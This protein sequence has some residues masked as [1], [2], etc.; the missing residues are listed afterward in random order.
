MFDREITLF[1]IV[2]FLP[3]FQS[4]ATVIHN[5]D[6]TVSEFSGNVQFTGGAPYDVDVNFMEDL[7]VFFW[8]NPWDYSES[9]SYWIFATR[10][11]VYVVNYYSEF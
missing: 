2:I 1:L 7:T 9:C 3:S 10:R 11:R 8:E 4:T 5:F 6:T